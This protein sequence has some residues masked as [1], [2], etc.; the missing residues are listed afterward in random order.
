MKQGKT[1]KTVNLARTI[2][3]S[4]EIKRKKGNTCNLA[5]SRS[6]G[7]VRQVVVMPA[8]GAAIH[9][10]SNWETQ[11]GVK[12]VNCSKKMFAFCNRNLQKIWRSTLAARPIFY[13][14]AEKLHKWYKDNHHTRIKHVE[15]PKHC[16]VRNVAQHRCR[17][18]AVEPAE[19]ILTV[20]C[21]NHLNG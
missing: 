21:A 14:S 7:L 17:I 15:G 2:S 10:S 4:E 19:P 8:V 16:R 12:V 3:L 1:R 9:W 6:I 11:G 13:Q 5:L 18:A 20:Y